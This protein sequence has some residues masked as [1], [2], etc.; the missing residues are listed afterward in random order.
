MEDKKYYAAQRVE[1]HQSI[2]N[3]KRIREKQQEKKSIQDFK[4]S[5][6]EMDK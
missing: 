6:I 5:M 3:K 2:I 1:K 4:K